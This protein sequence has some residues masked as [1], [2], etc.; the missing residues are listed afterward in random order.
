M[1][2]TRDRSAPPARR[3]DDVGARPVGD[4]PLELMVI[5]QTVDEALDRAAKFIDDALL[6]DARRLRVVH[7]VGTG[8]LRAA[9]TK[10]FRE[11]PLVASTERAPDNEGGAGATI[12]E[13]KD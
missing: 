13:L 1:A 12:V 2:A 6:G 8:K 3:P 9:L 5:G 7:G 4:R 10:Y 11:H